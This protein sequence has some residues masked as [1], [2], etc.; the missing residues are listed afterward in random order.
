MADPAPPA[1]VSAQVVGNAFIQQYYH[2][3][4]QSPGLVHRFYQDISKLGRPEED[5]SMS[6]TTTMDAINAKI[7]SLN[8]GDFKAEIKSVVLKNP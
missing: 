8:Y 4:H 1:P 3:L 6:M 5:G 7:L 2:I